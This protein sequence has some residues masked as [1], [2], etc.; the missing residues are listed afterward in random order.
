MRL[1]IKAW[2]FTKIENG[3]INVDFIRNFGFLLGS[4]IVGIL[5][6]ANSSI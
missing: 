2:E 6:F 3:F 4:L 1:V 5:I